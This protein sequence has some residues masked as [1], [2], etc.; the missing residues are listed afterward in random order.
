MTYKEY[1]NKRTSLA[2]RTHLEQAR[3]V[4]YKHVYNECYQMA[5]M[6]FA[7]GLKANV[8]GTKKL[9]NAINKANQMVSKYK[10]GYRHEQA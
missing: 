7:E 2:D 6:A 8:P 9:D 1:L 10:N 5:S 3:K 4:L